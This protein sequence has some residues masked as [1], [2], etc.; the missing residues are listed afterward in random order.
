[1]VKWIVL[2]FAVVAV[3]IAVAVVWADW[4]DR[5]VDLIG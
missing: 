4:T 2:A 1:M 5:D 3:V